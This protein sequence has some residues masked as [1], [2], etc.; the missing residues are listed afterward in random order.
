MFSGRVEVANE[1]QGVCLTPYFTTVVTSD[2]IE[3]LIGS[4]YQA[5]VLYVLGFTMRTNAFI[6]SYFLHAFHPRGTLASY[7]PDDINP[8]GLPCR[9]I[10]APSM[11][12]TNN[13]GP[14]KPLK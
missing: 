5:P 10:N 1:L 6:V 9:I 3:N 2:L 11:T 13:L 4:I 7:L 8:Q 12:I 14:V